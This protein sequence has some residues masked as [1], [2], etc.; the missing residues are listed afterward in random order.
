MVFEPPMTLPNGER[1]SGFLRSILLEG[2]DNFAGEIGHVPIHQDVIDARNSTLPA[3]L[4]PLRAVSCTC[5]RSGSS[6]P[7]HLEAYASGKAAAS[8]L[9]RREPM[10]KVLRRLLETPN[11]TRHARVLADIGVL[12]G[13]ALAESATLLNPA[14]I[15]LTGA[16]AVEPVRVEVARRLASDHRFGREPSVI[17]LAPDV[18]KYVRARGAALAL[19]RNKVHRQLPVI[20]GDNEFRAINQIK[21][22]TA[23]V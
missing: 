1:E 20:F 11:E 8:R 6:V 16:L 14:T 18:N 12:V 3:E 7:N 9:N 17:L 4:P 23:R 19:I 13:E 10:H 2:F 21:A 22:L 15:T 5:S